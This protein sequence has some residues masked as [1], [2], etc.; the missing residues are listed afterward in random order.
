MKGQTTFPQFL[1][2]FNQGTRGYCISIN[3]TILQS[4]FTVALHGGTERWLQDF[5]TWHF[6]AF[7]CIRLHSV[8][9]GSYSKASGCMSSSSVYLARDCSTGMEQL[10]QCKIY[11]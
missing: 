11:S 10:V 4:Q 9:F 3:L 7:G 6:L 2:R 8:A 1:P 5:K